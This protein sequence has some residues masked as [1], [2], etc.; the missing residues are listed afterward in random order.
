MTNRNPIIKLV[1]LPLSW[2]YGLAMWWRNMF[3]DKGIFKSQSFDIPVIVVGNLAVGGTGKTPHI[4]YIIEQLS[5]EFKVAVLSRG[6]KRK[7][8]G[9]VLAQENCSA[10]SIGD[11][12]YQIFRKFDNIVVAVDENRVRGIKRLMQQHPD[13]DCI[14]LDDAFQHRAVQAGFNILLTEHN[15]LY[16]KDALMP[17][18]QLREAKSGA[19][20]AD[21]IVVT[22]CPVDLKPIDARIIEGELRPAAYQKLH[23]S[24]YA[25]GTLYPL[26][27][28]EAQ[29]ALEA[30]SSLYLVAGIANPKPAYDHLLEKYD[31][32]ATNFYSDHYNFSTKDYE[33]ISKAFSKIESDR[34]FIVTTEKDASRI[35]SDKS[36]PQSLKPY[37]YV[38]PIKVEF[39]LDS[40]DKL[41]KKIY[42]Y[43]RKNQRNG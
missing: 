25:Y 18:G 33:N 28:A 23:F 36:F 16:N 32:A 40:E 30:G 34:K 22:K 10:Q 39:M 3:Y 13:V 14:L 6:Y 15:N 24:T 12:P 4:E 5:T 9:F 26:F 38:L 17:A 31:I 21:V 43:V 37:V 29:Q 35:V 41:I 19:L 8:K 7:T 11:E 42:N 2:V 1:L 27:E 20:R